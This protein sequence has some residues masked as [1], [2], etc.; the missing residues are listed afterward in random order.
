MKLNEKKV[1]QTFKKWFFTNLFAIVAIGVTV[2][3]VWFA[4]KLAPLVK[5]LTVIK[6]KVFAL[7]EEITSKVDRNEFNLVYDQLNKIQNLLIAHIQK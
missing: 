1:E 6:T 3:N 7:Q 4:Y 5:D 2:A